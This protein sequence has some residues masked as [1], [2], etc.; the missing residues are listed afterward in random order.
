MT[1]TRESVDALIASRGDLS[2]EQAVW[3]ATARAL[4]DAIDASDAP[5]AVRVLP[6]LVR[7]L[8]DVVGRLTDAQVDA[9]RLL[10]DAFDDGGDS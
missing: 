7:Q 10:E 3:A 1:T 8:G 5:S 9:Q 6:S 4:A 2:V